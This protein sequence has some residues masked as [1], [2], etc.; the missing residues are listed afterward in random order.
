MFSRRRSAGRQIRYDRRVYHGL[1][2]TKQ[3]CKLLWLHGKTALCYDLLCVLFSCCRRLQLMDM[4]QQWHSRH[5]THRLHWWTHV[6]G[7]CFL[8]NVSYLAVVMWLFTSL[9][10]TSQTSQGHQVSSNETVLQ[11]IDTNVIDF[12]RL[13]CA[14][15]SKD[16]LYGFCWND[17]FLPKILVIVYVQRRSSGRWRYKWQEQQQNDKRGGCIVRPN[18]TP[19]PSVQLCQDSSTN[20]RVLSRCWSSTGPGAW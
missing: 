3:F 4:F 5:C 1:K 10:W 2:R 17:C 14:E 13:A 11:I 7:R 19:C 9:Q 6:T 15:I 20:D 16:L 18:V 8:L 12:R